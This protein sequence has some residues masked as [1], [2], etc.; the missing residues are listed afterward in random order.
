LH[1]YHLI[2]MLDDIFSDV[3]FVKLYKIKLNLRS[4]TSQYFEGVTVKIYNKIISNFCIM[5]QNQIQLN[6][7]IIA[8]E[9]Y[10]RE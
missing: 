9:I 8:F 5:F 4:D 6:P 3:S 10:F 2:I 1:T 7:M